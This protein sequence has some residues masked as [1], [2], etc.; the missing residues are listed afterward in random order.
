VQA[1]SVC[2]D[3]AA[4]RR[5]LNQNVGPIHLLITTCGETTSNTRAG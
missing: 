2:F 5:L 1:Y 3:C 4:E